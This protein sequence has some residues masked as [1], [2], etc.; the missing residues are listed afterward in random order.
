MSGSSP[1]ARPQALGVPRFVEDGQPKAD[2]IERVLRFGVRSVGMAGLNR[3]LSLR[4]RLSIEVHGKF[5]HSDL[6]RAR[7]NADYDVRG[8]R[9]P[10]GCK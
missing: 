3:L 1:A 10:T 6:L 7:P 8:G 2:P 4:R 5:T 9:L